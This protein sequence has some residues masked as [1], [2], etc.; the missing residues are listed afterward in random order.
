MQIVDKV[1]DVI[2]ELGGNG[3]VAALCGVVVNA[4]SMWRARGKFPPET[5]VLLTE[6][7]KSKE[8]CAPPSLWRMREAAE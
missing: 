1:D 8:K 6:A 5:Y 7:L 4:P 2:D 3:V